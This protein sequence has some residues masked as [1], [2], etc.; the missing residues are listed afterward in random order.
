MKKSKNSTL[1]EKSTESGPPE[2]IKLFHVEKQVEYDGVEMGVLEN[3]IPYL[4]E[5]GLAR[6]CGIDRKVLNRLAINWPQEKKKK[7]GA[8]INE[9][10]LN[11]GYDEE[12]LYLK[13]EHNGTIINAYTEP[14][15]ISILEYYAFLAKKRREEATNA[16]R[17]LARTSFRNFIY[18]FVGYSPDQTTI[19]SW[20]H[21]HDRVDILLNSVPDGF[22]S[23]FREIATIIVPMIRNGVIISDKVLPDISVGRFWSQHWKENKL[24]SV[25]GERI[26]YQHDYPLYYPQAKSNPQSPYAYPESALGEFRKWLRKNYFQ[27]NFPRYIL[28]QAKQGKLPIYIANEAI[29]SIV[30]KQITDKPK[31]NKL[32]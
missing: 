1:G 30:K 22:F 31:S 24:S 15:C 5:S 13:S 23:I 26:K 10:L 28:N 20:K 18:E 2:Q 14:V 6:M 25:Y 11:F 4:T 19:V 29:K 32:T 21:F 9:L 8:S 12:H 27:N 16:F 7:R 17:T 3:G